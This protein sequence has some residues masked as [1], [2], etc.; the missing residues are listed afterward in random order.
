MLNATTT[1]SPG[2]KRSTSGADAFHD[3]HRL[4]PQ[5]VAGS[6]GAFPWKKWRSEP[7]IAVRVTR[8]TASPGSWTAA[9]GTS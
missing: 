6:I 5:D 3:A 8:T 7:Q 9:S 4:V 1:R 2:E